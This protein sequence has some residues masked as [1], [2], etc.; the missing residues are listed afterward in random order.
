[1]HLI[2]SR[3]YVCMYISFLGD[4]FCNIHVCMSFLGDAFCTIHVCM[5]F[6]RA[7]TYSTVSV[8]L[9]LN[10]NDIRRMRSRWLVT[11]SDAIPQR[12]CLWCD[13]WGLSHIVHKCISH[14]MHGSP[15]LETHMT[16]HGP[17]PSHA[18]SPHSVTCHE[19]IIIIPSAERGSYG[20]CI[21]T[22]I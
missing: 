13:Q 10:D 9:C 15:W 8:S 18:L 12:L 16:C 11:Q 22:Y 4:A 1:M 6:L 3:M 7:D 14:P 20:R 5:S 21:H 17:P 2:K 19:H